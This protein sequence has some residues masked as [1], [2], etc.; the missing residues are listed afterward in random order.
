MKR[1]VARKGSFCWRV[2]FAEPPPPPGRV[3]A[4]AGTGTSGRVAVAVGSAWANGRVGA[5]VLEGSWGGALL[6]GG[7]VDGPVT[8]AAAAGGTA[9]AAT[10]APLG[11]E[12]AEAMPLASV[13]D[14]RSATIS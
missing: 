2:V 8:G 1:A 9:A 11:S 6:E 4:R 5:N 3:A 13:G 14:F 10:M 12:A 7:F